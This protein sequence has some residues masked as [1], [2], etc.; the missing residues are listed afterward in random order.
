M[1]ESLTRS[2]VGTRKRA[3]DTRDGSEQHKPFGRSR[4]DK[5]LENLVVR[6]AQEN[7]S[8]GYNRLAGALMH[9]GDDISDQYVAHHHQERPHQGKN[10]VILLPSA[11][12][13]RDFD[14]PI[15]GRERL[16]GLRTYYHRKAA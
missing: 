11:Q 15:D 1:W 16:G 4:I 3:A 5:A 7:R 2:S 10:N 8:W 14:A 6:I 12:A 9:L 13:E